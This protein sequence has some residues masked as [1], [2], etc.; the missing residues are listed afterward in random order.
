MRRTWF[1]TARSVSGKDTVIISFPGSPNLNATQQ[2]AG[3]ARSTCSW[4]ASHRGGRT[5]A[6]LEKELLKLYEPQLVLS[7][8]L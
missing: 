8:F 5:P 2:I 6:E 3:T 4:S 7:R 1:P